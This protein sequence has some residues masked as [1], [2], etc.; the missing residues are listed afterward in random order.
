MYLLALDESGTHGN[1]PVMIVGGLA[2]H[3]S[4]V[5]ALH[6]ALDAVLARHLPPPCHP[7]EFELHA[8]EIKSPSSARPARN[9]YLARPASRWLPI[10]AEVRARVLKDTMAAV[11]TAEPSAPAPIVFA[12]VV[13]RRHRLFKDRE[14]RAYGHVLSQFNQMLRDRD[15]RGIVLHDNRHDQ[16]RHIQARVRRQWT[17]GRTLDQLVEVPMFVDSRSTRLLQA[18]DFACWGLWRY[19]STNL[20]D[21][22]WSAPL[23]ELGFEQGRELS[24]VL[25]LTPDHHR[26]SCRPCVSRRG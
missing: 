24:G 23:L 13:E 20:S 18:A 5:R 1:A 21:A 15:E 12:A 19:Y 25:H 17:A 22:A 16:E 10:S 7:A 2:V 9:G 11:T 14:E 6:A 4:T 8:Q 3:E 26:C